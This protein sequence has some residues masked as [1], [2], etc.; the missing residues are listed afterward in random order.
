MRKTQSST[1]IRIRS[2]Q[3]YVLLAGQSSNTS[4][5]TKAV[6]QFVSSGSGLPDLLGTVSRLAIRPVSTDQAVFVNRFGA[7]LTVTGIQIN[8]VRYC[9]EAGVWITCHQFR[10]TFGR[11]MVEAKVPVTTIQRLL[12]HARLPTTEVYLHVSDQQV[13]A[14]YQAT[15]QSVSQQQVSRT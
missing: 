13:Q 6:T 9:R 5:A 8:L 4:A 14:D 2:D 10:H 11:H 15:M 12:G 1:S 7:R 3:I